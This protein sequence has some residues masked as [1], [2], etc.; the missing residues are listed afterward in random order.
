VSELQRALVVDNE[1]PDGSGRIKVRLAK[2]P[3]TV[4]PSEL[5]WIDY[6]SPFGGGDHIDGA[7]FFF[8][9]EVGQQVYV[10][11]ESGNPNR[12]LYLGASFY[13]EGGLQVA[14][15]SSK[16]DQGHLN[17]V[18]QTRGGNRLELDDRVGGTTSPTTYGVRLLSGVGDGLTVTSGRGIKLGFGSS[19]GAL[20]ISKKG[21]SLRSNK[22]G[23]IF[24]H[25]EYDTT[26]ITN[27]SEKSSIGMTQDLISLISQNTIGMFTNTMNIQPKKGLFIKSVGGPINLNSGSGIKLVTTNGVNMQA[28]AEFN[29]N[30]N[31]MNITGQL[32]S[33]FTLDLPM[34]GDGTLAGNMEF[35]NFLGNI[36]MRNG[37]KTPLSTTNTATMSLNDA[38]MATGFLGRIG[39]GIQGNAVLEGALGGVFV[40]SVPMPLPGTALGLGGRLPI[41]FVPIVPA[42]VPGTPQ[43]AV[44]GGNLYLL[45]STFFTAMQTFVGALLATTPAWSV[46]PVGPT[47]ASPAIIAALGVLQGSL[48][49]LQ[50]A[51]LSPVPGVPTNI[52]SSYVFVDG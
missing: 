35:S 33:N 37:L 10:I 3:D 36:L 48:V 22:D 46:S 11:N 49:A 51:H 19:G 31:T 28:G 39:L 38:H 47:V 13:K 20:K 17:R 24:V 7:G 29:V 41:P 42:N 23:G 16:Q 14:P 9:P 1:D 43:S 8:V 45:L 15:L 40:S 26:L 18:I 2:Q 44:L 34:P 4:P 32:G 5:E 12:L 50:T 30:A 6:I 21:V 25:D 27:G 52:L